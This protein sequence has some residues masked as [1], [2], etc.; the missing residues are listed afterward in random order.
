MRAER[1]RREAERA[2]EEERR[3]RE[4]EEAN[5]RRAQLQAEMKLSQRTIARGSK[6]CP[7]CAVPIQKN[8][9]W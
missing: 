8:G 7:R 1:E 9:G 6:P 3:R 5:R 4:E 2:A